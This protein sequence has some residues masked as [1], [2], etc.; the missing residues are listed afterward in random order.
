MMM[1]NGKY[2]YHDYPLMIVICNMPTF[3]II[4]QGKGSDGFLCLP[5]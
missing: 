4:F 1:I 5:R 2:N 3:K